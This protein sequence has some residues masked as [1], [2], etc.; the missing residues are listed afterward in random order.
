M[1]RSPIKLAVLAGG[2]A[3]SS[4]A[5]PAQAQNPT[6]PATNVP[7]AD[8]RARMWAATARY[9]YTDDPALATL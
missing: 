2:L 4:G 7:A 1:L 3:L 5:S 8:V 6:M 9:V